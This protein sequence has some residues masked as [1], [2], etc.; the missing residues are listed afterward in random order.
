MITKFMPIPV[1]PA[2]S[3]EMP[4]YA[5]RRWSVLTGSSGLTVMMASIGMSTVGLAGCRGWQ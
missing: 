4:T 3:A 1:D 5:G 2:V